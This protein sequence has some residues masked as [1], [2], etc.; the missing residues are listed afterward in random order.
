MT[1]NKR[2]SPSSIPSNTEESSDS[3]DAWKK[4][5][6][7]G[8]MWEVFW[9]PENDA[10][11]SRTPS[12][13]T[14]TNNEITDGDEY[15]S[16]DADWYD[17][18]ITSYLPDI[19][20]FEV[21]FVGEDK[22]HLMSLNPKFVRPL[23]G[24]GPDYYEPNREQ[25]FGSALQPFIVSNRM[26]IEV[27]VDWANS[28]VGKEVEIFWE[29]E[30]N[31]DTW[32]E[33]KSS[34]RI[35][36]LDENSGYCSDWYDARIESFDSATGF[37][38]VTFF[39]D[40]HHYE[41]TLKEEKVRPSVR[42]WVNRT[43]DILN[44]TLEQMSNHHDQK[45]LQEEL[46]YGMTSNMSGNNEYC[47]PGYEDDRGMVRIE[48]LLQQQL[49]LLPNLKFGSCDVKDPP[50]RS[51]TFDPFSK[52]HVDYLTNRIHLGLEVCQWYSRH[53]WNTYINEVLYMQNTENN[54][55]YEYPKI[56][57]KDLYS[58]ILDGLKLFMKLLPF[59]CSS[60]PR[61]KSKR[62]HS[63]TLTIGINS[64]S[65]RL[66]RQ[67][68]SRDK[69]NEFHTGNKKKLFD[70]DAFLS[71][72]AACETPN[73]DYQW[74]KIFACLSNAHLGQDIWQLSPK[75]VN[76][77]HREFD[78]KCCP[79]F[80]S[81][82][83]SNAL[84]TLLN[85]V[86]LPV[87]EWI[88]SAKNAVGEV[89]G[90][91]MDQLESVAQAH[92]KPVE[93]FARPTKCSVKEIKKCIEALNVDELLK[94]I[95][96]DMYLNFLIARMKDI[97]TFQKEARDTII[98]CINDELCLQSVISIVTRDG[99][100]QNDS[101]LH[102]FYSLLQHEACPRSDC[103]E[104]SSKHLTETTI[105]DAIELRRWIILCKW[106]LTKRERKIAVEEAIEQQP[107]TTLAIPSKCENERDLSHDYLILQL[108]R[109]LSLLST[110]TYAI[111]WDNLNSESC[112]KRVMNEIRTANILLEDEERL[113]LMAD[114]FAWHNHATSIF[115][116]KVDFKQ[117]EIMHK[118]LL[119]LK[120]GISPSRT[121]MT[122]GILQ[123][124][125][126][127][128][129]IANFASRQILFKFSEMDKLVTQVFQLGWVW[130]KKAKHVIHTLKHHGNSSLSRCS[131]GG[132]QTKVSTVIDLKTIEELLN[133]HD[134][135]LFDFPYIVKHLRN[136]RND[137]NNWV[138]E[139]LSLLP[140]EPSTNKSPDLLL[141]SLQEKIAARPKG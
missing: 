73:D 93:K 26:P 4:Q 141:L 99:I 137:A 92:I 70:K 91:Q 64:S 12:S 111:D 126:I 125:R 135:G 41:M 132:V 16:F 133:D 138:Q 69:E 49:V 106:I 20:M 30:S 100:E 58:S 57:I 51:K 48:L 140:I 83:I 95:N 112:C 35:S 79:R 139:F 42:A 127:D 63:E 50:P 34:Q 122:E 128:S 113:A 134:N 54:V 6:L 130:S 29:E 88:E 97:E 9:T 62:T 56:S 121:A 102:K 89:Y 10:R 43:V 96:L 68:Q 3:F 47:R 65:K 107:K 136:V 1:Q 87:M 85:R 76:I 131:I 19:D 5:S 11:R 81:H 13:P 94:R 86:W 66:K 55:D 104:Q 59:D 114:A 109:R 123:D 46:L 72:L 37:F 14:C 129:S 32:T 45:M 24:S 18:R 28:V 108:K 124:K 101:T 33:E 27:D 31:V 25:S 105:Q 103:V 67:Q 75:I 117:V 23:E 53:R 98:N 52:A 22:V 36:M 116:G 120:K 77:L 39:G 21:A 7:V 44:L 60:K 61:M 80:L 115:S 90:M 40:K 74:N 84:E 15:A 78:G 118:T 2:T 110:Q 17:A 38:N 119:D 8:K 71:N 82:K